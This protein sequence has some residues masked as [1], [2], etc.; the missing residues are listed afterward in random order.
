MR[1][2]PSSNGRRTVVVIGGGPLHPAAAAH[3]ATTDLVLAADSGYDLAVAAGL[4]P[5]RLFGDLDS[6]SDAGLS[7][8][9]DAGIEIVA[10]PTDKDATDTELALD[11]ALDAVGPGGSILLLSGGGDRFDH[12]LASLHVLAMPR[13]AAC[14]AIDGWFG[15]ALV[16]M[17]HAPRTVEVPVTEPGATVS[18]VPL[19]DVEGVTTAGLAWPLRDEPLPLGTSRGV[20]NLTLG[21]PCSVTARSGVLAAVI[22]HAAPQEES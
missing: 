7:Q 20:S 11:A 22:P 12:L 21:G 9:R 5:D 2:N 13:F 17:L 18:L 3:V 16:R 19:T 8:A 4:R 10:F 14:A 15:P 6:I 1:S